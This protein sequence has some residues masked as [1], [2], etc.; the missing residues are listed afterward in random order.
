MIYR[1][2][3]YDGIQ[4]VFPDKHMALCV[5]F[6]LKAKLSL[7][8]EGSSDVLPGSAKMQK[9]DKNPRSMAQIRDFGGV[10]GGVLFTSEITLGSQMT[11]SQANCRPTIF[12]TYLVTYSGSLLMGVI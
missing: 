5:P 7:Q 1:I 6:S 9:N 10:A 4:R 8:R 11:F 3:K 2:S 12:I